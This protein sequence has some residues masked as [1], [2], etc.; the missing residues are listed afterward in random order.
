MITGR[1]CRQNRADRFRRIFAVFRIFGAV[2]TFL[3]FADGEQLDRRSFRIIRSFA[4]IQNGL[5]NN[6]V[7]RFF[8][9]AFLGRNTF[10]FVFG[11]AATD[12]VDRGC[13]R[14]RMFAALG[15]SRFRCFGQKVL[16]RDDRFVRNV[17]GLLINVRICS[18]RWLTSGNGGCI[19]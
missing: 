7:H 17:A 8:A 12:E 13:V 15:V 6:I 2:L 1:R 14:R 4:T 10:G 11:G 5:A 3:W 9:A 18:R 19:D 16:S